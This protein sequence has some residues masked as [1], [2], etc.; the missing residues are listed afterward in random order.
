MK[1]K[2]DLGIPFFIGGVAVV[3]VLVY[4]IF[5]LMGADL[6]LSSSISKVVSDL[7][8]VSI[9]AAVSAY[10]RFMIAE[11]DEVTWVGHLYWAGVSITAAGILWMLYI[12]VTNRQFND[13]RFEEYFPVTS[14]VLLFVTQYALSAKKVE[15]YRNERQRMR[16]AIDSGKYIPL[17]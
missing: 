6:N 16:D 10:F 9:L 4:F 3:V 11:S 15:I 2:P 1:K 7:C 8:K 17:K 5:P 12:L 14:V 13:P